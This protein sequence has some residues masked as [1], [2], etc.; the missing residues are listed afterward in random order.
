MY[1]YLRIFTVR[2]GRPTSSMSQVKKILYLPFLRLVYDGSMFYSAATPGA[3]LANYFSPS[4]RVNEDG[5][6]FAFLGIYP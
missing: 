2:H 3:F 1:P 4:R 5:F 6:A